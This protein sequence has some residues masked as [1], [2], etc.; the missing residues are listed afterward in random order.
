[1]RAKK[2]TGPSSL[3][4]KMKQGRGSPVLPSGETR[5]VGSAV[6]FVRAPTFRRVRDWRNPGKLGAVRGTVDRTDARPTLGSRQPISSNRS[7]PSSAVARRRSIRTARIRD[8]HEHNQREDSEG[9]CIEK[10]ERLERAKVIS[11]DEAGYGRAGANAEIT[12]DSAEREGG[13][14]LLGRDQ[15][16]TRNWFGRCPAAPNPAPPTTE[17]AKPARD[18]RRRREPA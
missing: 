3:L 2:G 1:M 11:D 8:P 17:Q 7:E 14:A 18:A 4:S 10:V 16:Q 12:C 5:C 15:R 13:G 6:A 9:D